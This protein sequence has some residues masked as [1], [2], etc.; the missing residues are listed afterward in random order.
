M[1]YLIFYHCCV[2][3]VEYAWTG[4]VYS[5]RFRFKNSILKHEFY[6]TYIKTR[7][8][9]TARLPQAGVPVNDECSYVLS[10]EF[11]YAIFSNLHIKYMFFTNKI[12]FRNLGN[13]VTVGD[14][15]IS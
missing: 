5:Y 11:F 3:D 9:F 15:F 13:F 1:V 14:T 10:N 4:L 2:C 7:V 8:R 12:N 6:K